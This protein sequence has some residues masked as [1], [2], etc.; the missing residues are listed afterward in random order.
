MVKQWC[1]VIPVEGYEEGK[2]YCSML[3]DYAPLPKV[4]AEVELTGKEERVKYRFLSPEK[5]L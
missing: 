1:I 3:K 4:L 2:Y 5:R